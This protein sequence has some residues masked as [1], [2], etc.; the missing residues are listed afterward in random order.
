MVQTLLNTRGEKG[1]KK[2]M[3]NKNT[4][5]QV[6]LIIITA[7]LVINTFMTC[8]LAIWIKE[9]R[10]SLNNV[11]NEIRD[12]KKALEMEINLRQELF[13]KL[14]KSACLLMKYN[15]RLDYITAIK[16][17]SK[18]YECSDKYVTMDILTALIVVESSANHM[19]VSKK[20]AMGL[21]QVMPGIWRYDTSTLKNPYKN[22][23][24]GASILRQYI[25]KHGLIGGLSAYNSG[26]KTR[27][28]RYAKNI[29]KIANKYF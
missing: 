14:K 2:E 23:E 7:V 9:D 6:L 22:I 15:H 5:K 26:R 3:E 4:L 8:M 20:G 1:R 19:A 24:I 17:A 16:Y 11:Q 29:L 12:I 21:T 10:G 27:S 28:V 13:P 25:T 18:I